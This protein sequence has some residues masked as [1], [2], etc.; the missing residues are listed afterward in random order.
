ME[1]ASRNRIFVEDFM[2]FVDV[3]NQQ[4]FIL[5]KGG[6]MYQVQTSRYSQMR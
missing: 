3:L 6:Q 2:D 5:K 1:V 4:A